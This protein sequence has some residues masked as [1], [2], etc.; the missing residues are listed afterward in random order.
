LRQRSEQSAKRWSNAQRNLRSG[1]SPEFKTVTYSQAD[2]AD[3]PSPFFAAAWEKVPRQAPLPPRALLNRAASSRLV[4][5][6][7]YTPGIALGML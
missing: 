7:P 3:A 5:L 4:P 2:S 1:G 6:Q